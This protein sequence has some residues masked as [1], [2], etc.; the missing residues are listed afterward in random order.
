MAAACCGERQKL[1]ELENRFGERVIGSPK[2]VAGR[3]RH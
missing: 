1:L 2:A 3:W